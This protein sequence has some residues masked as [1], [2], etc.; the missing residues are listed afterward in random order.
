MIGYDYTESN[1]SG[2]ISVEDKMPEERDS[3]FSKMKGT[4][5]W[6]NAMFERVSD[7]VIVCVEFEDGTRKT[8]VSKTHDG[9]WYFDEKVVRKRVTHWMPL[10]EPWK[11]DKAE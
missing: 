2:W 7:E 5:K 9:Q 4:D 10:P 6:M 1:I 3:I 8:T 11:G